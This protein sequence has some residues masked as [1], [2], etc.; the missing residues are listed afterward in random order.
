MG[1]FVR[2]AILPAAAFQAA[3]A[4]DHRQLSAAVTSPA[5]T[6]LLLVVTQH[7]CLCAVQRQALRQAE[8]LFASR[9]HRAFSG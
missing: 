9:L 6:G 4:L 1:C 8:H 2:Q 7:E 5:F 3:P